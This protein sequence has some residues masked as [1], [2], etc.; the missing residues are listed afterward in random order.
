MRGFQLHKPYLIVVIGIP[1]SGK[2]EFATKFADTFQSFPINIKELVD[3]GMNIGD[4]TKFALKLFNSISRTEQ[5]IVFEGI[6]GNIAERQKLV[7][8]AKSKGYEP[9]FVWLQLEPSLARERSAKKSA[10]NPYPI[11]DEYFNHLVKQ[12]V[13]P[14]RKEKA[15]IVVISGVHTYASQAKT[16]L[17]HL[18]NERPDSQRSKAKIVEKR[19]IK[20]P[21]RT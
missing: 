19:T 10:D 17:H 1:G 5:T 2:T 6:T 3:Y 14:E 9:V 20:P 15:K 4:A 12:F 18:T 7:Q 8:L 21:A 13:P 11:S 16:V